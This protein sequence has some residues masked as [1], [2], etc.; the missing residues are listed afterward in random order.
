M[1]GLPLGQAL[2][3]WGNFVNQELYGPPSTAWWSIKIA[4]EN[5]LV[6][7]EDYPSFQPLFAFEML[8][9]FFFLAVIWSRELWLRR[10]H[11]PSQVGQGFYACGYAMYYGVVRF[12]LDFMRLAPPATSWWGLGINQWL[13]IALVLAGAVGWV[14]TSKRTEEA[15]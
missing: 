2:G 10:H 5:R 13:M 1:F 4:P 8:A 9:T 14:A 12:G 11:R 15:R 7:Y 3:R 6:G